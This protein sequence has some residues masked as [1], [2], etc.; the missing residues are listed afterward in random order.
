MSLESELKRTNNLLS[1]LLERWAASN[2]A[3][4]MKVNGSASPEPVAQD[5][6]ETNIITK[7]A[8]KVLTSEKEAAESAYNPEV[9]SVDCEALRIGLTKMITAKAAM[10][11]DSIRAILAKY[12]ATRLPEVADHDL[13]AVESEL[14]EL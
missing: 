1:Q 8:D 6:Q 9:S 12:D 5:A 3:S 2:P 7:S 13:K 4:D 14:T 11:A 10:H